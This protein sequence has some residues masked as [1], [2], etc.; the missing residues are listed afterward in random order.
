MTV[1]LSSNSFTSD[2]QSSPDLAGT[3]GG[4]SAVGGA[5]AVDGTAGP[6]TLV[7][8]ATGPD[9]GT[10]VLNGGPAI[11]LIGVTSFTCSTA[12]TATIPSPSTIRPAGCSGLRAAFSSTAERRP[13]PPA[14]S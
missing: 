11:D 4:Q 13:A 3:P 6:D 5:V 12:A 2:T 9:S 8:N 10:Y 14:I 1:T 7:I